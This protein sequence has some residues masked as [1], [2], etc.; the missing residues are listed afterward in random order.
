MNTGILVVS[1]SI[2]AVVCHN[3][4]RNC[5]DEQCRTTYII[6]LSWSPDDPK[7]HYSTV[8][9]YLKQFGEVE[10]QMCSL[11]DCIEGVRDMAP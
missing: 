7:P 11:G 2:P 3:R 10:A 5:S 1:I 4:M 6:G 8:I 9:I